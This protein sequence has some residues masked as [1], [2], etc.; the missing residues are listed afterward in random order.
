LLTEEARNRVTVSG[1]FISALP[2]DIIQCYKFSMKRFI[3]VRVTAAL[4]CCSLLLAPA[5]LAGAIAAEKKVSATVEGASGS[6]V[7]LTNKDYFPVLIKAIEEAGDEIFICVFSFKAGVHKNSYPDRLLMHLAAAVSR[8]VKVRVILE[9][10][11]GQ[12]ETLDAQNRQTKKLL[13]ER[14]AE[15]YLD[16]PKT[17]THTKMIV[18]DRHLVIL[19][20][21]NFTQAA[22]KYNNE[23][24][25]LIDRPDLALQARNYMLKIIRDAK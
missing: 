13:E 21:H 18:V 9:Y 25:V 1:F 23:I 12:D 2:K 17:T 4:I 19:G 15:V 7:L 22:L 6:V 16:S 14:G 24:S 20:S 8:G 10:T 11:G 3:Y 5:G